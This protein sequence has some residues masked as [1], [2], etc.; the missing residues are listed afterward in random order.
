MVLYNI[1]VH[2]IEAKLLCNLRLSPFEKLHWVLSS[3]DIISTSSK[4][5]YEAAMFLS[6]LKINSSTKLKT[7]IFAT[8]LS[9]LPSLTYIQRCIRN[10]SLNRPVLGS[11]QFVTS[12]VYAVSDF[13]GW[14]NS[15]S[16]KH[17]GIKTICIMTRTN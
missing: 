8:K 6:L 17:I 2:N 4:A 11:L 10:S 9:T 14:E 5:N 16:N 12:S 3:L 1:F 7:I 13:Y 15:H